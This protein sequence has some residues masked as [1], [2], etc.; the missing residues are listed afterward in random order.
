MSGDYPRVQPFVLPE[1]KWFHHPINKEYFYLS[2]W[3]YMRE[4][5]TYSY[6]QIPKLTMFFLYRNYNKILLNILIIRQ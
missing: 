2:I 3:A 1:S 4:Q 6:Y 5:S